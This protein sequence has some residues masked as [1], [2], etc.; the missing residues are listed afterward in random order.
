MKLIG[1]LGG[2]S[3]ASTALYQ[4]R[5][6][7]LARERFGGLH[8]ANLLVRSL[9][10]AEIEAMQIADDWAGAGE[11]LACEAERLEAAGAEL[12]VLATNTMHKVADAITAR[13]SVPFLHIADATA[14]ALTGA[15]L[16]RPALIATAY[17][18]EQ[19]FYTSRLRAAGL[20][21]VLPDT[22]DR[23]EIH[24]IIFEELCRDEVRDA[25]RQA[26]EAIAARLVEAG[27]DSLILGCTEV[28]L[29][30]DETNVRVPVFDTTR[31]HCDRAMD[32]A[33][34]GN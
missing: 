4:A 7:R 31:I 24:R 25:S 20:D 3:A 22:G 33:L 30:L 26:F 18:M 11:R 12:V 23:Q 14:H 29:L 9:D 5:L 6:N 28:G 16:L 21:V 1:I 19:D 34:S 27:A 15:G 32:M 8:S 17:T 13:L 2:M 10:F